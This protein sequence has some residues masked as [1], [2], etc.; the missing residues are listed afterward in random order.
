MRTLKQKKR[1]RLLAALLAVAMMFQ[2][3]PMLAFADEGAG[4]TEEKAWIN[5]VGYPTLLK[6]VQ[7]AQNG[8][9]IELGEGNY[10]LCGKLCDGTL[11]GKLCDGNP[12]HGEY[13]D[14]SK[15]ATKDKKLTF[16][17]RGE[18]TVWNIGLEKPIY[19]G[20]RNG[21]YSFDGA[22]TVTFKNMTLDAGVNENYRGFIRPNNTIVEN[23]VIKGRTAYWG[24]K[25][26]VFENT[27]FNAPGSDYAIWTYSSSKMTFDHCTFNA[28]GRVINVFKDGS[29]GDVTVNFNNC[30]VNSS[31][32]WFAKPAMKID[33]STM[34]GNH[35]YTINI[36][37]NNMVKAG[38]DYT[39]CSRVFGY[40][41]DTGRTEVYVN[42][43]HVWGKKEGADKGELKTHKYS[44]G[45]AEH[46][47]TTEKTEWRQWDERNDERDVNRKC[48]YCGR[49]ENYTERASVYSLQYNLNGGTWAEGENYDDFYHEKENV[50]LAKAPSREGYT[51]MWWKDAAGTTYLA[52]A[53]T[54]LQRDTVLTAQWADPANGPILTVE[55]GT[56]TAKKD[57][58]ELTLNIQEVGDTQKATVPAGAEVTV[59]L[60]KDAIPQNMNFDRWTLDGWT[61]DDEMLKNELDAALNQETIKFTMPTHD[62]SVEA[63]YQGTAGDS[64]D[65][66]IIGTVVIGAAGA[67]LLGWGTYQLGT[68]CLMK[69]Y[70]LPYFPSNRSVLAMMLWEDAGKPMPSSTL[71]YPD[72]GQKERDMDLQ[73][74]ARWAMEN[75]LMPDLNPQKDL[76][77]EEVKFYPDDTVSKISALRAWRKAQE[78]KQKA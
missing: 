38:L 57:G 39:T 56:I 69:Y 68:E 2:M 58:A 28:N 17:G 36:S 78:L 71:L 30:T 14:A 52:G 65:S 75:E 66:S 60:N 21:D 9:T 49:E 76:D 27:T 35:K 1:N 40:G 25:S 34:V 67:A 73:H 16:V 31:D 70:G 24:Y 59:E 63:V 62:L 23:C 3:L 41:T 45:E 42:G 19:D 43:E 22:D 26:A 51:F 15:A 7:A 11:C 33:D 13:E 18:K 50:T 48:Q 54:V 12:P 37:G 29:E 61:L 72:V 64:G 77:P 74:A 32:G 6:A 10:T 46:Q 47:V 5:G 44:A 4:S 55:G 8:D 53:E 20:E